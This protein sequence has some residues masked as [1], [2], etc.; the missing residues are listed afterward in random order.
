MTRAIAIVLASCLV[1]CAGTTP[2]DA[3]Q[4]VSWI[5]PSDPPAIRLRATG[6]LTWDASDP[7]A[8]PVTIDGTLIDA[9]ED[10]AT[11][12]EIDTSVGR[13]DLEIGLALA[14]LGALPIGEHVQITLDH[15]IVVANDAGHLVMGV[16]SRRGSNEATL[17]SLTFRQS[18]A[19]CVHSVM[20]AGCWRV[21][22]AP[23][24]DVVSGASVIRLAP[25]GLWRIPNEEHPTAE[26]EIVRSVRAHD[27]GDAV[28][29]PMPPCTETPVQEIAAI[30][31]H[32][33]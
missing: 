27:A 10:P 5:D 21:V 14:R 29:A 7:S 6:A 1:A 16:L 13:L 4:N 17:G 18:Y 2:P 22:A 32:V 9:R 26:I 12:L 30:V 24:V 33:R 15:G 25:N 23:L 31:R 3:C 28:D 20:S 11:L 8:A 19:E